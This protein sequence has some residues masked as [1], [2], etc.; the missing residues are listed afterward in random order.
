MRKTLAATRNPEQRRRQLIDATVAVIARKGLVSLR[1]ADVAAA[2]KVSYGV[3]NFYFGSKDKLLLATLDHL[4][5]EY[6]VAAAE[7]VAAADP[8]ALAKLFAIIDLDFSDRIA[9]P[10]KI[11]A[12]TAFWSESRATPAFRKRC[13]ELQDSFFD[14]T[15]TLVR[16]ALAECGRR[17]DPERLAAGLNNMVTGLW[18][19]LQLRG[20]RA[21][22]RE[23]RR[24]CHAW[25]A[26]VFPEAAQ[27]FVSPAA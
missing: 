4:A 3:V 17:D 18:V 26:A 16:D 9:S 10:R 24:V 27:H 7:T 22:R 5:A 6:E 19:E 20:G 21:D 25:L 12:W 8:S 15:R 13:V 23:A 2:A 11:A 14:L 1:I